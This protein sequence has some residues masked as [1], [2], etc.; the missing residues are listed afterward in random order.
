MQ[1]IYEDTRIFEVCK[2]RNKKGGQIQAFIRQ[3]PVP[4]I[5]DRRV[6]W[7]ALLQIL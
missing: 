4:P 3:D 5:M 1:K 2:R 7:K 6:S